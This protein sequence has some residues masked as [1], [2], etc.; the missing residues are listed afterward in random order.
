M[1]LRCHLRLDVYGINYDYRNSSSLLQLLYDILTFPH[2]PALAHRIENRSFITL[3]VNVAN[4]CA[5]S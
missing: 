3:H 1:Y 2:L 5:R 4:L